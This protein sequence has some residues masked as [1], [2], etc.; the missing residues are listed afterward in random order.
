MLFRS[1]TL[2]DAGFSWEEI[3]EISSLPDMEKQTWQR[4]RVRQWIPHLPLLV[5]DLVAESRCSDNAQN[6]SRAQQMLVTL[7]AD[8][9]GVDAVDNLDDPRALAHAKKIV[10][11]LSEA[12]EM[13]EK[14]TP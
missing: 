13:H 8:A 12:I 14:K 5:Q 9:P 1:Q 11:Q 3:E 7:M 10:R 2:C 6:R 4:I